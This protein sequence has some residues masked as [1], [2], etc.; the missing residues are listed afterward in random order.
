MNTSSFVIPSDPPAVRPPEEAPQ[1]DVCVL[2]RDTG[3]ACDVARYD[4]GTFVVSLFA[5]F[6]PSTPRIVDQQYTHLAVRTRMDIVGESGT[7]SAGQEEDNQSRS[8]V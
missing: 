1:I 3:R 8:E 7:W 2:S 4:S 5:R 6:M